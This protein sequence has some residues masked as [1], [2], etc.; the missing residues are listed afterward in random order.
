MACSDMTASIPW[1]LLFF[2]KQGRNQMCWG[3]LCV[4]VYV[5][6]GDQAFSVVAPKLLNNLPLDI[7][8]SP[9]LVGF[10]SSLKT[11]FYSLAFK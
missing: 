3:G 5:L 9:S 11:Y 2:K 7:R 10:K 1:D 8:T 6:E 4:C